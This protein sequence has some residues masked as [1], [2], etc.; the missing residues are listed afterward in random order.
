MEEIEGI[1]AERWP[2]SLQASVR[3]VFASLHPMCLFWTNECWLYGNEAWAAAVG[4]SA[5]CHGEAPTALGATWDLLEAPVKSVLRSGVALRIETGDGVVSLSPVSDESG[6]LAGVLAVTELDAHASARLRESEE[7]FRHLADQSPEMFWVADA[8]GRCT[9]LNERWL[10]FTGLARDAATV[11]GRFGPVHAIDLRRVAQTFTAAM[12]AQQPFRAEY[13]LRR[14]DGLYR[15]MEEAATPRFLEGRFA[16]FVG[17]LRDVSDDRELGDVLERTRRQMELALEAGRSGTF[18]WDVPSGR[19]TWSPQLER[20]YGLAPGSF[21]GTYRAWS[22]LVAL[23]DFAMVE[24]TLQRCFVERAEAADFEFRALLPDGSLC[25]LEAKAR[26]TYA[27]NGAPRRMIGIQVDADARKREVEQLVAEQTGRLTETLAEMEAFSYSVSH[28]LR[29]PLRAMQGFAHML[30]EEC[31]DGL[32][33]DGQDFLRRIIGASDRMDR[34]IRD[35]LAYSQ[36]ARAELDL[37]PLQV[38]VLIGEIV[39]TDPRLQ[40]PAADLVIEGTLPKVVANDSALLQCLANLLGNAVKFVP[41]GVRPQVRIWGERSGD[42]A[43]ICVRDNGI[44]IPAEHQAKIFGI[45][46]RLSAGY[47]GTGIGLALVRKAVDR[48]GGSVTVESA[49]NHGSTFF[50]E[51]P[52]A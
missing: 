44:G 27:P 38:D 51:L 39:E 22:Q 11:A 18:D 26:F 37:R 7:R 14:H 25:W 33:P 10:E 49:V 43:K 34:L 41:A 21:R 23:E 8:E 13:R 50:L 3:V 19:M 35:L 20:L 17:S 48:M 46:Q 28:D 40:A 47:E 9:F 4:R 24:R 32:T 31:S 30:A 1:A 5:A 36:I 2:E 45:F 52:A 16:G 42:R 29:A 12:T 15:W 6:A